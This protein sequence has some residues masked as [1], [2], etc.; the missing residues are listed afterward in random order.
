MRVGRAAVLGVVGAI[1]VIVGVF[2]PWATAS[3]PGGNLEGG[4]TYGDSNGWTNYSTA[5]HEYYLVKAAMVLSFLG[6]IAILIRK[7][8]SA[9]F[10]LA[11]GVS[12]LAILLYALANLE[13]VA[14]TINSYHISD[15]SSGVG[16]GIFVGII[17]SLMLIAGGALALKEIRKTVASPSAQQSAQAQPK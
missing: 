8:S 13:S 10:G 12:V 17:G 11:A 7:Q 5:N 2:L 1:L 16:Y 15:W 4:A 14:Y 9:M 6:A 3:S